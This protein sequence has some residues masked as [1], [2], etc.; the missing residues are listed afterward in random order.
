MRDYSRRIC[1][2][3]KDLVWAPCRVKLDNGNTKKKIETDNGFSLEWVNLINKVGN[4]LYVV[5]IQTTVC[6]N[7]TTFNWYL[8]ES[9]FKYSLS[10]TIPVYF[11]PFSFQ[12]VLMTF[13]EIFNIVEYTRLKFYVRFHNATQ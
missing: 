6:R 3:H 9:N 8:E 5:L 1:N 13:F 7:S 2:S 10:T 11:T 12:K 4:L